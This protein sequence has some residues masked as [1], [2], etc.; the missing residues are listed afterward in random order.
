MTSDAPQRGPLA[1]VR[2]VELGGLGPGPFCGMVL[3]DLGAEL[4]CVERPTPGPPQVDVTSRGKQ[5]VQLDIR[6]PSGRQIVLELVESADAFIEPFR[7]GV[8]ERLGVGPAHCHARNPR[9]V[10]ARMTGWGQGGPY[11]SSAGHDI[12]YIALN[13]T[14][15]LLA[16]PH[17]RPVP[18][19]NLLGDYG[20]GA[21]FLALG[22]VSGVLEAR[23]SGQGQVVDAAM[24]DGSALLATVVHELSAQGHWR[25]GG[26]NVLQSAAPYYRTYETADHRYVAVGAIEGRFFAQLVELLGLDAETC[27]A[28]RRAPA[29]W[30]QL[31]ALLSDTFGVETLAHWSQVFEGTDACV[32]PVLTLDEAERHA[33][34]AAR[35]TF[36]RANGV[37][38]PAAAPRFSRTAV[39]EP[40]AVDRDAC[41][42]LAR[43]GVDERLVSGLRDG[44]ARETG[45]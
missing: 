3:A 4:L 43:W 29:T 39:G 42:I 25:A 34:L 30:P 28:W 40:R 32:T 8:A 2:V 10:Y 6:E 23:G 38:Q 26:P 19:L 24:V 36:V 33:H 20:G 7:P 22:V 16:G 35:G 5:S 1:G 37:R 15:D 12:N 44:A 17:Q 18:P 21:L 27:F 45:R 31:T 13:G 9:L 41:A 11:G 14:L